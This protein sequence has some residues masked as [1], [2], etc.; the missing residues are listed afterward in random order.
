MDM[1]GS[2]FQDVFELTLC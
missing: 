1:F 2:G